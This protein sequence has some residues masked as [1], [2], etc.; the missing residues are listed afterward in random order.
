MIHTV[1]G[2]SEL[3]QNRF[4]QYDTE[5]IKDFIFKINAFANNAYDLLENLLQWSRSQTGRIIANPVK[6]NLFKAVDEVIQI[7]EGKA[8]EKGIVLLNN[9]DSNLLAFA[10]E[11][12]FKTIVRNLVSN[13]IKFTPNGGHVKI[14]TFTKDDFIEIAVED[15]GVGIEEDN[16]EKLFKINSHYSTSGTNSESGTGLGLIIVKEF[17]E[18]NGGNIKVE[19]EI[20][21][22]SRF[23]FTVP[24]NT[25]RRNKEE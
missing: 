1:I 9:L 23:I 25:E 20:N 7:C 18:K 3:L 21:K 14:N 2:L 10:D 6:F 19:S 13:A 17:V 24:K 16:I 22:G 15:T 5:K 11:N 12:I 4:D 8:G